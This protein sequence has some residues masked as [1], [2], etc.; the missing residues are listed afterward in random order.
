MPIGPFRTH[1]Q[2][3]NVGDLDG[4][5]D[6]GAEVTPESLK[7][8]GLVRKLSI[9]VKVLGEG[10][11][12]KKLTVSA[13]GFSKSAVEK[14]EAAGGSVTW[15]RGEPVKKKK[16]RHKATAPVAEE[17]EAAETEL[18]AETEAEPASSPRRSR[19]V[20]VLLARECLARPRASTARPLHGDD[21]R[22]L[23][24]RLL[25]P[26]TGRQLGDDRELL[27]GRG[28]TILGLLNLFSGGA[29]SQFSLFALGI[30]PYVTASIILQLLTVVIPR[31]G[32]LQKEGEAA[33]R[34]SRS[35]RATSRSYSPQRRRPATPSSS[36]ARARSTRARASSS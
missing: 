9:D 35:T 11:L 10:E 21:P 27:L 18:E 16:K 6:A 7:A 8:S 2:P 19:V 23:P 12:T 29:L 30:M 33:T 5:F 22:R 13:H 20:D 34:R 24:A 31:L 36:A 25:D 32:E 1:T 28:D 14:I 4:R 17:P 26:R 15:L 3:V